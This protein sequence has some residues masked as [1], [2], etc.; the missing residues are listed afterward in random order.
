[1]SKLL[2]LELLFSRSSVQLRGPGLAALLF[3]LGCS[4]GP[5]LPVCYP[6][7]G[8]VLLNN[9][10]VAE[11]MVVL[12][13]VGVKTDSFP[14]PV[15]VTDAQGNFALTTLQTGDGAPVGDY[16]AT[17]VRR[18]PMQSGDEINRSGANE[19]PPKYA[20]PTTSGLVVKVAAEATKLPP[21]QLQP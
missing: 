15:A 20:E 3:L 4:Y 18:Q 11:A 7:T 14:L 19:L 8:K 10:P 13:Q 9:Q 5:A 6:V 16:V 17:V 1:M 2:P 21:F 12:H